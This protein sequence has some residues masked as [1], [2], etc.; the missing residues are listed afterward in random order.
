MP[1][2]DRRKELLGIRRR[3]RGEGL[4]ADL[5]GRN[6]P[7]LVGASPPGAQEVPAREGEQPVKWQFLA[8]VPHNLLLRPSPLEILR[9]CGEHAGPSP[10]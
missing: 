2:A 7:A 3:L 1:K 10:E 9:H 6:A 8:T 5:C 4:G